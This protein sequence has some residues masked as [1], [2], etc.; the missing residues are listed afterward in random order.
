M[1]KPNQITKAR[2][3]ANSKPTDNQMYWIRRYL[4]NDYHRVLTTSQASKI[5]EAFSR[6]TLIK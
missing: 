6:R 1:N 4:P 5:I 3:D 2:R